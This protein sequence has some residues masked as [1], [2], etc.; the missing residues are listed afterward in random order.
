MKHF[1]VA[2]ADAANDQ[3]FP[4]PTVL[5]RVEDLQSDFKATAVREAFADAR[6]GELGL[7]TL[8]KHRARRAPR[9][10]EIPAA[11]RILGEAT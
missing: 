6:S 7:F 2:R 10:E 9:T 4:F 5:R 8:E 3:I 11:S 1:L